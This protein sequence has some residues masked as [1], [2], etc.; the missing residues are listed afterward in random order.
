MKRIL[1]FLSLILVVF[2]CQTFDNRE[3]HPEIRIES[4][5]EGTRIDGTAIIV[6]GVTEPEADLYINDQLVELSDSGLF[7]YEVLLYEGVNT[8]VLRAE[9]DDGVNEKSLH[10]YRYTRTPEPEELPEAPADAEPAVIEL[11][12]TGHLITW[13]VDGETPQGVKVCI[14][15]DENPVYPTRDSD[16]AH[17]ISSPDVRRFVLEAYDGP[18]RYF[19]RVGQYNDGEILTYS[20]QVQV[21]L[22]EDISNID[23]IRLFS[24]PPNI[25]WMPERLPQTGFVVS[26]S[27]E[28]SPTY[29]PR[30]S[31][32]VHV[33]LDAFTAIDTLQAFDGPGQYYVRVFEYLG[34]EAGAVSNQLII[35]LY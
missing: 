10:I 32:N 6:E 16:Q 28:P 7:E 33:W 31:D 9:A 13:T 34:A 8:I 35:N 12:A 27:K 24:S 4:P 25:S 15:R 21:N 29:P 19:V 5:A 30:D 3:V 26:W 11:S 20:N 22:I 17:Y 23:S 2:S 14:S 1:I 18:G